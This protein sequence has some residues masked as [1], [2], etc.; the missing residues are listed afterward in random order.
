MQAKET[1]LQKMLSGTKV[2]TLPLFQRRYKWSSRDWEDLWDDLMVQYEDPDVISGDMKE[3]DGHFLGSIVLH[4]APGPA[5]TV[6]RFLLVDGQQRLTTF[7]VLI[8]AFRDL[9]HRVDP[10]WNP[11]A[12]D[13]QYLTNPW[14]PEHPQRLLPTSK[15]RESYTLTVHD[16]KPT[17]QV[18]RAYRFFYRRMQE[19]RKQNTEDFDFARFERALMLRMLVVDITTSP[20]DNVNHIFHTLNHLGQK[21]SALDLIRNHTFT[22][23]DDAEVDAAYMHLW[24]PMETA[25]TEKGLERY[26]WAQLVRTNAKASQKDLFTHFEQYAKAAWKSSPS[27]LADLERLKEEAELYQAIEN[28][29]SD[30]AELAVGS[31]LRA[32]LRQLHAWGSSTHVPLTLHLLAL[33]RQGDATEAS[34]VECIGHIESFLVRRAIAGIPSNNLNRIF[35]ALPALLTMEA[36]F[37]Q[38]VATLL[39]HDTRYW[40]TDADM[41]KRA[42]TTPIYLT[43]RPDQVRYILGRIERSL[44]AKEGVELDGLQVEHVLPQKLTAAWRRS[45]EAAG[46]NPDQAYSRVHTLG[47]LTLTGHNPQLGVSLYAQKRELLAESPIILNRRL[48]EQPTWGEAEMVQRSRDLASI[49]V[50]LWPRP[51]DEVAAEGGNEAP[52]PSALERL[53]ELLL[54]LPADGWTTR[55]HLAEALAATPS[56]VDTA[57]L[58]LD[59]SLA[60]KVL[61]REGALPNVPSERRIALEAEL[62]AAGYSPVAPVYDNPEPLSSAALVNLLAGVDLASTVL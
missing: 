46:E 11:K 58:E 6:A 43:S 37:A 12:Y 61:T 50:A 4:P 27:V 22:Q 49:A 2:F 41:T 14:N 5:S 3:S 48:V 35:T 31:Q 33:Q 18:G 53:T 17:G 38:Q 52:V 36:D 59:A 42:E 30:A 28:P 26:L 47:N 8:A 40:P 7:L 56:Q 60:V 21:L 24:A 9:R 1:S 23:V 25:L 57:T 34:I 44:S 39:L 55:E 32:A 29:N 19:L 54:S 51:Q 10:S 62:L 15:D 45:L 16:G 13:E 20:G